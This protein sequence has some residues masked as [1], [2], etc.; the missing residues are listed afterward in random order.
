MPFVLLAAPF[1]LLV[2]HPVL[3][4]AVLLVVV[5]VTLAPILRIVA[6]PPVVVLLST[7]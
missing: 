6:H 3:F 5:L 2:L 7:A 4:D 1:L